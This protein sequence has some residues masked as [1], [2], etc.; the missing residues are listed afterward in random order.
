MKQGLQTGDAKFTRCIVKGSVIFMLIKTIKHELKMRKLRKRAEQI[1]RTVEDNPS[2]M[3]DK[4]LFKA[5]ACSL[6]LTTSEMIAEAA[7]Y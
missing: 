5:Y 3:N 6:A 1:Y 7:K 4:D 2:I